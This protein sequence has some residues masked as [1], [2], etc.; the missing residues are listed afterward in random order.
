M[1]GHWAQPLHQVGNVVASADGL[2]LLVLGS[3]VCPSPNIL[4]HSSDG[5]LSWTPTPI[6]DTNA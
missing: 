2:K 5:G 3:Y 1:D 4:Y 6:P